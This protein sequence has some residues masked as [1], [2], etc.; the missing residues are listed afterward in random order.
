MK[1]FLTLLVAVL[2]LNASLARAGHQHV[3]SL[4]SGLH[5]DEVIANVE[6]SP[7]QGGQILEGHCDHMVSHFFAITTDSLSEPVFA[8]NS[9]ATF[10]PTP[11]IQI[12]SIPPYQPPRS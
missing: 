6:G 11:L 12:T 3:E 4:L 2:L 7:D 1:R 10:K 9:E 8:A 5:S